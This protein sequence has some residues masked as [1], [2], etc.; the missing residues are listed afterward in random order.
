M[1]LVVFSRIANYMFTPGSQYDF[2]TTNHC[3]KHLHTTSNGK[4]ILVEYRNISDENRSAMRMSET[5]YKQ[6]KILIFVKI[7]NI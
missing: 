4:M 2:K 1:F 3:L 7:M 6:F 5:K